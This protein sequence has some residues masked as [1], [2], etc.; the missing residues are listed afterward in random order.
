VR[1]QDD[2]GADPAAIARAYSIARE[3]FAARYIWTQIEGLDNRIP[4][5]VQY[6]AMYQTTRLLRHMTYWLLEHRRND[7][8]I[9]RGVLRYARKVGD[10][11]HVLGEVLSATEQAR[12]SVRRS[13]LIEQHVPEDLAAR[14]ASLEVLH[15]ALDLVEVTMASHFDIGYAAKAYFDLG[16]RIGL[17]WI[18]EQIERLAADGHWQAVARGTLRDNLYELQRKI[19]GAALACKG[20][21][22]GARVDQWMARH[23]APVDSLKR[24]VVDLRTGSAPDFATLSVALQAVRRLAQD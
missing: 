21:D 16:D 2:T 3:V 18:K 1:A 11:F 24:V 22:P 8:D 17:T 9:E 20:R 6:T 15:C 12:L 7:L 23:S 5:T 10:L 19:T 4:A 14:I 13:Q